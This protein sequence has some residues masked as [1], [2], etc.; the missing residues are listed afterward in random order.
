[1]SDIVN[2]FNIPKWFIPDGARKIKIKII[3]NSTC[4]AFIRRPALL[5]LPYC[6]PCEPH[7]GNQ[8]ELF[9]PLG[10]TDRY[11]SSV[12]RDVP[13]GP[14]CMQTLAINRLLL[15]NILKGVGL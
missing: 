13:H 2:R 3:L 11:N 5:T 9:A 8:R 6:S 12:Y 15:V 14:D 4:R 1:M 7:V 10:R